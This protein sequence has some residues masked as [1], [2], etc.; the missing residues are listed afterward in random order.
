M[1]FISN[2]KSTERRP[3]YTPITVKAD[4]VLQFGGIFLI[5]L[6]WVSAFSFYFRLPDI[7]SVHFNLYGEMDRMGSKNHLILI[8][9]I[10]T[11]LFVLMTIL[12]KY[13]E[14]YNYPVKIT[15]ENAQKQ[16]QRAIRLIRWLNISLGLIFNSVLWMMFVSA[17]LSSNK[18]ILLLIPAVIFLSFI[19]LVMYLSSSKQR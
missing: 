11:F 12:L 7:I 13:P 19:P 17:Q 6:I 18:L 2:Q 9:V 16:Y 10:A 1:G 15:A 14:S 5:I 4:S 8:P 3:K